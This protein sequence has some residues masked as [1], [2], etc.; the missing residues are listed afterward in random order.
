MTTNPR[1]TKAKY[2]LVDR[3]LIINLISLHVVKALRAQVLP[4][5][6]NRRYGFETR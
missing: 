3:G 2:T 6:Q 4:I 1:A 5:K